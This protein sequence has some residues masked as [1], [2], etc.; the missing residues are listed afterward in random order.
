MADYRLDFDRLLEEATARA[1]EEAARFAAVAMFP[2]HGFE[3]GYSAGFWAGA[4]YTFGSF[5][6]EVVRRSHW[7]PLTQQW[8]TPDDPVGLVLRGPPAASPGR[9]HE[10]GEHCRA[11]WQ[12]GYE[13]GFARARKAGGSE[14]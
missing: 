8:H 13:A 2:P 14:L 11:S 6:A 5:D 7:S 10:C 3:A 1:R 4:V 12:G 9:P